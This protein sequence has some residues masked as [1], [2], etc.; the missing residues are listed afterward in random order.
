MKT[1]SVTIQQYWQLQTVVKQRFIPLMGVSIHRTLAFMSALTTATAIVLLSV[2]M[3]GVEA[4][5]IVDAS[6]LGLGFIYLGLA[7]DNRGTTAI[8]QLVTGITL[9]VLAGLQH[10]V[11]PDFTIV[12]G[13][14]VATWVG[15]TVFRQLR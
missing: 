11:S 5:N 4:S 9:L 8:F 6:T 15:I 1:H 12:S 2:W 3:A 10:T 14:L 13:V 7:T